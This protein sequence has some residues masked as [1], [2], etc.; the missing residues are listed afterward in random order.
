MRA[1]EHASP[2]LYTPPAHLPWGAPVDNFHRWV[3]EAVVVGNGR[4]YTEGM[5]KR[6]PP[7]YASYLKKF[8]RHL[9]T[10][11]EKRGISQERLAVLARIDRS[12][13]GKIERGERNLNLA[14]I[15]RIANALKMEPG[16][17]LP[18]R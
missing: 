1:P 11:R 2:P 16:D 15:V 17:L 5:A 12:N 14:N 13:M 3:T 4:P 10:E 8:G 6:Q 18:K 7:R 9:R